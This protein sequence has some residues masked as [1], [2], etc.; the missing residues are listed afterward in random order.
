M[1]LF[2]DQI[3]PPPYE[4]KLEDTIYDEMIQDIVNKGLKRVAEN[5][6]IECSN[7]EKC[8]GYIER[9][10]DN[11]SIEIDLTVEPS[12]CRELVKL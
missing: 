11:G 3:I 4:L 12:S 6:G 2:A 5:Y 1:S 10:L 8:T 9:S 7:L